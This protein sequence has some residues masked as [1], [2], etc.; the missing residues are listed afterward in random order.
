MEGPERPGASN[1][2]KLWPRGLLWIEHVKPA[3]QVTCVLCAHTPLMDLNPN[4][5]EQRKGLCFFG[6]DESCAEKD[7]LF[8]PCRS[9]QPC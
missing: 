7:T 9:V 6:W 1:S 8:C 4:N 2:R 5:L 3:T